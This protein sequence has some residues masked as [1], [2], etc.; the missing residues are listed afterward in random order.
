MADNRRIQT[1]IDDGLAEWLQDRTGRMRTP[2]HN[3]Q[4]R[5][6][7]GYSSEARRKMREQ[8]QESPTAQLSQLLGTGRQSIPTPQEEDDQPGAEAA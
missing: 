4:A 5:I 6:E 1:R 2:S 8:D 7:L 3:E